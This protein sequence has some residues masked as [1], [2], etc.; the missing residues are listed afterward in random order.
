[1][2]IDEGFQIILHSFWDN[3]IELIGRNYISGE[4]WKF[5]Q[6][7]YLEFNDKYKILYKIDTSIIDTLFHNNEITEKLDSIQSNMNVVWPPIN[8][9]I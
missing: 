5:N 2:E 1:V 9:T 6:G 4:F 3:R 8:R 7:D